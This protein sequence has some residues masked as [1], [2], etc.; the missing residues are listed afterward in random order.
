MMD[1]RQRSGYKTWA[2][3]QRAQGQ[4]P[5]ALKKT[6]EFLHTSISVSSHIPQQ[7]SCHVEGEPSRI[8]TWRTEWIVKGWGD[9]VQVRIQERSDLHMGGELL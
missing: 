9:W 7:R 8:I 3:R 5:S 2:C 4:W 1:K 6:R